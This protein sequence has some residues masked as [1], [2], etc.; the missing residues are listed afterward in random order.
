MMGPPIYMCSFCRASR[1]RLENASV[2]MRSNTPSTIS[3]I[4]ASSMIESNLPNRITHPSAIVMTA[5]AASTHQPPS[6]A[7]AQSMPSCSVT[8]PSM[9]R[10]TPKM[11]VS[12]PWMTSGRSRQ[13]TP[14]TSSTMP[15]TSAYDPNSRPEA[16]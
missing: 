5:S 11:T 14:H 8:M 12:S 4:P 1:T 13:N 3:E 10:K 6:F 9:T 16:R 2:A 7:R 15:D